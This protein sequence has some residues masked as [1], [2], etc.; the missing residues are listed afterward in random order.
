MGKKYRR[1]DL[2]FKREL[3]DQIE[4]KQLTVSQAARHHRISRSLIDRW[5]DQHRHQ[6]LGG[7][8]SERERELEIENEKLKTKVGDLI[9]QMDHLKKWQAWVR[10]Q[11]NADTSVITAKNWAQFRKPAK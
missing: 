2:A 9:M 7:R 3:I 10:Q 5:L 8:R 4:A 1:Y 11:K 6:V